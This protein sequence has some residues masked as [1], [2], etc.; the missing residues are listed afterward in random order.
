MFI[1]IYVNIYIYIYI[2]NRLLLINNYLLLIISFASELLYIVNFMIKS[3][4]ANKRNAYLLIQLLTIFY[5]N[6]L[7]LYIYLDRGDEEKLCIVSLEIKETYK[8][9]CR[10]I[11]Y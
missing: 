5:C 9:N 1:R 11:F 8:R 7:S 6:F 2:Y 10:E 4:F 3:L